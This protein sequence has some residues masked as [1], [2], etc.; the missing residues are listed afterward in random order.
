[1]GIFVALLVLGI[2][3]FVHELGHFLVMR[4]NG[5]KVLEFAIGFGPRIWSREGRDGTIYS[6]RAL[7]LGGFVQT[8]TE[9]SESMSGAS[10]WAKF[11][12]AVAGPLMNALLGSV[13]LTLLFYCGGTSPLLDHWLVAWLPSFLRPVVLAF[14]GSFGISIA[15]PG[16]F[17]YMVVTR[18]STMLSGMAGPIGIVQMGNQIGSEG[19]AF[20]GSIFLGALFFAWMINVSVA[21]FNLMPLHPLDG[22]HCVAAVIEKLGGRPDGRT[23]KWFRW[24]TA[25]LFIALVV[26]VCAVDILRLVGVSI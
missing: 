8:P 26:V 3:I 15:T 1:M 23:I 22:G 18:F 12:I 2:A 7:P 21:G 5:V 6:L 10:P 24:L 13:A 17:A 25:I 16:I 20:G 11:K 4:R 14:V 9:G 19:D